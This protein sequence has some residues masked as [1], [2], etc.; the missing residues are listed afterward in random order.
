MTRWRSSQL[1]ALVL[2]AWISRSAAA[3]P[4][5]QVAQISSAE[6]DFGRPTDACFSLDDKHIYI[7]FR[8]ARLEKWSIP[9]W[10]MEWGT[11]WSKRGTPTNAVDITPSG[12]RLVVASKDGEIAF[13]SPKNGRVVRLAQSESH[14]ITHDVCFVATGNALVVGGKELG[15]KRRAAAVVLSGK[16]WKQIGA[17]GE[18][19]DEFNSIAQAKNSL[20]LSGLKGVFIA[21]VRLQNGVFKSLDMKPLQLPTQ[22]T[23]GFGQSAISSDGKRVAVVWAKLRGKKEQ[24]G[25]SIID[26]S[27]GTVLRTVNGMRDAA[28][29]LRF[30]PGSYDLVG[31]DI[32]GTLLVWFN[33]G[34]R[35]RIELKSPVLGISIGRKKRVFAILHRESQVQLWRVVQ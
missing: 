29:V 22:E 11:H 28:C 27:S 16:N 34:A 30:L 17:F 5:F 2:L 20:V 7:G 31:V 35:K 21:D 9:H 25:V 24:H 6:F 32:K 8:G 33:S 3:Q 15:L 26:V 14:G 13:V 23:H 10:K 12:D 1:L 19:R 18:S 4:D